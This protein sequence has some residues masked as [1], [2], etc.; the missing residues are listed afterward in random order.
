MPRDELT[1][2]NLAVSKDYVCQIVAQE[3]T[4]FFVLKIMKYEKVI[5]RKILTQTLKKSGPS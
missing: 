5:L 1:G 4:P 3:S 2:G